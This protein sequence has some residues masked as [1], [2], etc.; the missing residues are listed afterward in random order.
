MFD[1]KYIDKKS[2]NKQL[3]DIVNNLKQQDQLYDEGFLRQQTLEDLLRQ[4]FAPQFNNYGGPG[5][6]NIK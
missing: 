2:S 1:Y 6:E 4:Y 3:L 5:T